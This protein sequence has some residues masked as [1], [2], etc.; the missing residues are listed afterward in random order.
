MRAL[1]GFGVVIAL[2]SVPATARADDSVGASFD[3]GGGMHVFDGALAPTFVGRF[4]IRFPL[5]IYIAYTRERGHVVSDAPMRDD[6]KLRDH[7]NAATI[8]LGIRRSMGVVSF[9][10][11]LGLADHRFSASA[12]DLRAQA[13]EPPNN[14][15]MVSGRV[16]LWLTRYTTVGAQI[17]AAL[18]GD[19]EQMF[20]ITAG[21][22]FGTS[23]TQ[24]TV[25]ALPWEQRSGARDLR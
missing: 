21:L 10:G 14:S 22:Q 2:A 8:M 3:L 18:A 6:G 9:A 11:D 7:V 5:G 16:D 25:F 20:A 15:F 24:R 13:N 17:G 19:R 23:D 12:M 1:V 4:A